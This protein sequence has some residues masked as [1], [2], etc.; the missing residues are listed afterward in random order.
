MNLPN[1]APLQEV[2]DS[3]LKDKSIRL[4]IKR[5]DMIHPN[6]SG[7]KW[8]KLYYNIREAQR[9][10]KTTLVTFGGAYSNHIAATAALAQEFGV[11]SIGFIRGEETLPLNS[12]LF[13]AKECGMEFRYLDRLSYKNKNVDLI[14]RNYLSDIKEFC[15]VIPEGGT[16][17]L[18][19]KGTSEILK[20][21]NID[22]DYVCCSCGTGGTMAG[23]INSI[24]PSQIV[25]GF[26]AL[27]GAS[28][29]NEEICKYTTNMQWVLNL[30]YHFG[31]YAKVDKVL[32]DFINLFKQ[33][34]SV[35]LDP[36][37]T[38]KMMFGLWDLIKKD[39]FSKGS[40]IIAIHTGGLQGIKGMNEH[41]K[42]KDLKIL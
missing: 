33:K 18:G 40:T 15:Y 21:I 24:K 3:I 2:S 27:K 6:I 17:D 9:F 32:I 34:H 37:Y 4:Y 22:F 14:V 19:V 5:E 12:T 36:I 1:N 11:K 7:N 41:I 25:Y 30:D 42:I 38:G 35:P 26:A 31:G 29:L 23:L 10:N 28:F 16:N 8:R 20:D 39:Y 13:F